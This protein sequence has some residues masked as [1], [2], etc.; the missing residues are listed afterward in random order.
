[1]KKKLLIPILA[2]GA[3]F[4]SPNKPFELNEIPS[5][6]KGEYNLVMPRLSEIYHSEKIRQLEQKVEDAMNYRVADFRED[7]EICLLARLILGEAA[8]ASTIEKIAVAYSAI[9]R[10]KWGKS[11]KEVILAPYQYSCFNEG[12]DSSKFLKN[13]LKYEPEE[14]YQSLEIS[15]KI[16]AGKYKDPTRGATHYYNPRL[17]KKPF[18]ANKLFSLGRIPLGNKKFTHHVFYK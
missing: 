15:K 16:L 2:A 18:W 6:F 4:T 5:Q 8:G 13:P 17:V 7:S 12:T 10:T 14:F 9:N 3:L 11:L 1:M